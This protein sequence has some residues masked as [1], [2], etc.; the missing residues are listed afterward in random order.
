M[1]SVTML[2]IFIVDGFLTGLIGKPISGRD[3]QK[4]EHT[5][6]VRHIAK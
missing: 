6:V 5:F 1:K 4:G 3:K 2:A